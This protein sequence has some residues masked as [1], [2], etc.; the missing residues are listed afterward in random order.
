MVMLLTNN[1]FHFATI[2]VIQLALF[3]T[4]A[5]GDNVVSPTQYL[6]KVYVQG[7][8]K[9]N[10]TSD[11]VF[12]ILADL[13]NNTNDENVMVDHKG[14]V[15][16]PPKIFIAWNHVPSL[17]YA[18]EQSVAFKNSSLWDIFEK[19]SEIKK[20]QLID[21]GDG[22]VLA[23]SNF[24]FPKQSTI[25]NIKHADRETINILQLFIPQKIRL[26]NIPN[27]GTQFVDYINRQLSIT[28]KMAQLSSDLF[29]TG[30]YENQ[31]GKTIF[32]GKKATFLGYW[33]YMDLLYVYGAF[34]KNE[35]VIQGSFINF[36]RLADE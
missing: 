13:L 28:S 24:V 6:K 30:D 19:V 21:L 32:D 11:D 34:F 17:S 2:L 27:N 5:K 9:L 8:I 14:E 1:Y 16:K 36:G 4:S 35:V 10:C 26:V 12:F 22:L 33:Q 7:E 31:L 23:P 3:M 15:V 25:I 18:G 20:R 29:I